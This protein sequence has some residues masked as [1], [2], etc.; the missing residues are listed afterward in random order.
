MRTPLLAVIAVVSVVGCGF[1]PLD[2]PVCPDD[3]G[4]PAQIACAADAGPCGYPVER[5]VRQP[6]RTKAF[7]V[8]FIGEGIASTAELRAL[9]EGWYSEMERSSPVFSEAAPL[10]NLYWLDLGRNEARAL[11]LGTCRTMNQ[12]RMDEALIAR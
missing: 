1:Q 7:D 10:T 5:T 4:L 6:D 11:R 2:I 12:L 9:T 8:L 3:G